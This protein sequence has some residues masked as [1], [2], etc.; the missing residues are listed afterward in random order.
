MLKTVILDTLD[1]NDDIIFLFTLYKRRRQQISAV[2]L[3]QNIEVTSP[4]RY[5]Y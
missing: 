3:K 1:V 2:I 5:L 4:T